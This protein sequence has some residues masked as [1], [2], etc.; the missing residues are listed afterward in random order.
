V[1]IVAASI[2]FFRVLIR[3]VSRSL[4]RKNYQDTGYNLDVMSGGSTTT[5]I[6]TVTAA[7]GRRVAPGQP[8]DWSDKSILGSDEGR[9]GDNVVVHKEF[10]ISYQGQDSVRSPSDVSLRV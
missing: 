6:R 9:N 8:D 1:T 2:P 10:K 3:D 5:N 7:R 4:V